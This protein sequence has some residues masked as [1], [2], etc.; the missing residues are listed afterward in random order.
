MLSKH[1]LADSMTISTK[2]HFSLLNENTDLFIGLWHV[3]FIC[4]TIIKHKYMLL[5]AECSKELQKE[6]EEKNYNKEE[7]EINFTKRNKMQ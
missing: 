7:K 6:K 3:W 1:V 2:N 5:N 4:Y